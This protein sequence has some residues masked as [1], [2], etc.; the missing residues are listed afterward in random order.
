MPPT[1]WERIA[2]H[3]GGTVAGLA[4][5]TSGTG[6]SLVFAATPVG[7]F[8]SMDAG[9]SWRQPGV[10]PT[11]PLADV[12][13]ASPDFA[14]DH[15]VFVCGV[16]GLYRSS[17][18]GESWQCVLVGSRMLTVAAAAGTTHDSLVVLAGT[19]SDGMLRSEDAGR[20]WTGANA[21]L[22][23]LTAMCVALSPCFEAD[24]TGFAG[25]ASGLYRTRNGGQAWRSVETGLEDP[26]V[27][28]LAISP[29]FAEDRLVVAGTEADGLLRSTDGGATWHRPDGLTTGG[30]AALAF[31]PTGRRLAAATESGI[32]VSDD[33]GDSWRIL[34]TDIQQQA[35]SLVF[36][37]DALLAG[38]HREGI[39][40]FESGGSTWRAANEGLAARL[41][42][43]LLLSPDFARDRS[44]FVGGL[45]DG[46]RVSTDGGVTWQTA[47]AEESSVHGIAASTTYAT[48]GTLYLATSAGI[49]VSPDRGRSWEPCP[50]GAARVV[51]SGPGVV[52]VAV[53]GGRLLVSL[54]DVRSWEPVA[55]P[56]PGTD[57]VALGVSPAYPRDRT[58]FA[59]TSAATETVLW[60]STDSGQHWQRWMVQSNG[61]VARVPLAVPSSYAV[62]GAVLIGV[63]RKVFSPVRHAEEVRS[64]ERRPIWRSVEPG[65]NVVGVT[66]LAA[67]PSYNTDRTLF[68]TSNAGVFVSRNGGERFQTWNE[69]L[70]PTR[71]VSVAVSPALSQDRLVYGLG[72]GGTLWRRRLAPH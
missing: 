63:G 22:L 27:Q 55:T 49:R 69:G 47:F 25:T 26:A 52:V 58:I 17:D 51:V 43:E 53:E 5:A 21:G 46:L 3:Y 23:D 61:G 34:T 28:C 37:G 44:V 40:R 59:A 11:V 57:T 48:D 66:A 38:F 8:H 31:G 6:Q 39:G 10:S 14:R 13:A 33:G 32:A 42:T 72:L 24:R 15:T 54:D 64:G 18:G 9:L 50:T 70:A 67:S 20:S 56:L 62:D 7:V 41:H 12:V 29:N 30:V 68:A 65:S 45:E 35:L 16:G 1:T 4:T 36:C 60:R 19:E 2:T 71:M